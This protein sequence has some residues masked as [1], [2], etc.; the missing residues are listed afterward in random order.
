M[1]KK[2]PKADCGSM[3]KGDMK[4]APKFPFQFKKGEKPAAKSAKKK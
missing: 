3:K 2:A 4:A 1:P